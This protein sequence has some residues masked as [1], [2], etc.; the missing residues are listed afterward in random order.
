MSCM[1]QENFQKQ[2]IRDLENL[3]VLIVRYAHGDRS[4]LRARDCLEGAIQ[5]KFALW[6][7]VRQH[8]PRDD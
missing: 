4:V 2:L 8:N 6:K 5:I 1:P 7:A 3:H